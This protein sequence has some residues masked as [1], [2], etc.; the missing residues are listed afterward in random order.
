MHYNE[1]SRVKEPSLPSLVIF[2]FLSGALCTLFGYIFLPVAAGIYASLLF[3]ESKGKPVFS[4]LVPVATVAL[5]FFL[6]GFY[7]L[8]GVAYVVVGLVIYRLYRSGKTKNEIPP[9]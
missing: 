1:I 2:A 8:E 5:N 7:S 9:S 3:A 4:Y 6:N